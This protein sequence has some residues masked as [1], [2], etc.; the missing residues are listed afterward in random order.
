MKNIFISKRQWNTI[1]EKHLKWY[2]EMVFL[3]Y[4]EKGFPY[5][6]TDSDFRQTEFEKLKH[7]D[8]STILK[9]N[10]LRQTMH[11]LGLAWS[12]FPHAWEV[13]CNGMLTPMEVFLDDDLFRKVIQ[14]RIRLGDNMSD[15]GIR[16]M[17]KI[18]TGTQ[19]VSNF[20]PTSACALYNK[21]AENGIVWDMSCG[22][23][24]RLLGF[25][26]SKAK[27]YIGTDPSIY[28]YKG[29]QEIKND[30]GEGRQIELYNI[31]SEDYLPT[32]ESLD[33]CFTS[34]PY[35]DCE[36]YSG[37][38]TQSYLKFPT[39][40]A[41]CKGFLKSP[42]QNCFC[43]LKK[44]GCMA[45]NIANTRTFPNLEDEVLLLAK[46]SGVDAFIF[47]VHFVNAVH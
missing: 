44:G 19:G 45:I 43:G 25:L 7:Y 9:D 36:H 31:G 35:F 22:W 21:F 10:I 11:G 2:I 4:R 42:F 1:S 46:D 23:G 20:R 16:K 41:W 30:F 34:P 47:N 39:K 17:L 33:F 38:P 27:K 6:P 5:Y 8:C 37:E 12:Y 40:E 15:A 13:R 18:F 29:C 3:H 28:S 14:K 32:E 26:V 24:G